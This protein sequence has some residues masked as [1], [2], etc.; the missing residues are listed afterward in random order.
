[1]N[2]SKNELK[3]YHDWCYCPSQ[4]GILRRIIGFDEDGFPI[5]EEKAIEEFTVQELENIAKNK[6]G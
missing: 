4:P 1:M 3:E 6:E 5:I 2:D